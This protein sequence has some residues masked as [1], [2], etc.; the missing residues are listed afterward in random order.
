MAMPTR[1]P[2]SSRPSATA[3]PSASSSS[4]H[5]SNAGRLHALLAG[6]VAHRLQLQL[7]DVAKQL[8]VAGDVHE[9]DA[10]RQRRRGRQV[11]QVALQCGLAAGHDEAALFEEPARPPRPRRSRGCAS[12]SRRAP[13]RCSAPAFHSAVPMPLAAGRPPARRPS[14]TRA[15]RRSARAS[16]S[17]SRRRRRAASRVPRGH[18]G[19]ARP[20]PRA[21]ARWWGRPRCGSRASGRRRRRSRSARING[22]SAGAR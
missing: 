12:S 14:A 21:K 22:G 17:R 19:P 2:P 15:G 10:D 7:V 5:A 13:V 6:D 1:S 20:A 11:A 16:R 18:A 8:A 9:L 3:S 4:C